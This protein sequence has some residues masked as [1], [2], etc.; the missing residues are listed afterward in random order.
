MKRGLVLLGGLALGVILYLAG[1]YIGGVLDSR[2][3]PEFAATYGVD[4]NGIDRRTCER[5]LDP[6]RAD[7][8]ARGID[9]D[10]PALS[11]RLALVGGAFGLAAALAAFRRK[12]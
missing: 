1:G 4:C 3:Y 11:R 6:A 8:L 9:F 10:P 2:A 5:L 12:R 7:A